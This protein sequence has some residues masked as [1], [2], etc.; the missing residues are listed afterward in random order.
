[1]GSMS[2]NLRKYVQ[3]VYAL[4]AVV[5]RVPAGTWDNASP[6]DGWTAREVLGHT[7][8]GMKRVTSI[9]T[10]TEGPAEQAEADVA[11]A[12]PVATW[13]A[14]RDTVLEAL[15]QPGALQAT[16]DSPMGE[17][18]LDTAVGMFHGDPLVHAWDIGQACGIEPAI[19]ADLAAGVTQGIAAMGD[20]LR[21][22]GMFG[23]EVEVDA[24]ASAVDKMI[25]MTGRNPAG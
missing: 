3:S 19:P 14:A 23:A 10:A 1:M 11:G 4:D 15:D 16:F 20:A 24:D 5:N 12:D 6:C 17:M 18:T 8:W 7:I 13:Q 9:A 2:E 21:S 22:P 25:A